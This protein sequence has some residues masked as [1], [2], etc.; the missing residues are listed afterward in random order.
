MAR[1]SPSL[2]ALSQALAAG[3]SS[4]LKLV[5]ECVARATDRSGEGER[6][7]I[8]LRTDEALAAAKEHDRLRKAGAQ[9][10]L[11]AG[12]PISIKDLFD[13]A[14]ERTLAGSMVLADAPPASQNAA[15]VE[16]L[17][18]AG[19][20]LIGRTNMSEFAFSGVG[21]NPHYGTPGN[22]WNRA[23]V[24]GGSSSGAAVSVA[25][26]M[27]LAAIGSDTGGSVRIPAA[28]CG[29]AAFKPTKARVPV[30]GVLPL[31]TT[32]DSIGPIAV[33]IADCALLDAV[34]S[35]EPPSALCPI[36]LSTLRFGVPQT[37]VF[38]SLDRDVA[39]AF[40][41][42]LATLSRA[43][44]QIVELQMPLLHDVVEANAAGGFPPA[45][46]IAWHEDLLARRGAD[47]D[48]HAR[49]RFE[50][51][52]KQSAADYIRL[53]WR[54]AKLVERASALFATY[55]ALLMPTCPVVAPRIDE[56][57]RDDDA[58]WRC[59]A[60]LLRNTALVN[61]LDGCAA[62]LPIQPPGGA[63]VG[64]MAIGGPFDDHRLLAVAAAIEST[65]SVSA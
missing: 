17:R 52:R 59:N 61:F 49:V 24:P 3:R 2:G 43:G 10:P 22:P 31:S 4:S 20:I 38:D 44:A 1:R 46:A 25:D 58:F 16:R 29:L 54:R 12:V 21:H 34:L 63:P 8:K 45:E 13:V 5:E 50:Q 60:L 55:D 33:S 14:G 7:F 56:I 11:L 47:Y 9:R 39:R 26:G 32:L 18:M 64:L 37:L 65:L 35:G 36:D 30:E 23:L 41:R 57:E 51:G 19:A 6:V 62:T 40:E 48:P 42:A 27:A 28:L 15:V 53:C